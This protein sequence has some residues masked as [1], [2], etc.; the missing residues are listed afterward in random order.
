MFREMVDEFHRTA[1]SPGSDFLS[2]LSELSGRKH[3]FY[4]NRSFPQDSDSLG[5]LNSSLLKNIF[6]MVIEPLPGLRFN[7]A[8]PAVKNIAF[9]AAAH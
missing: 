7:P 1:V 4:S 9:I 6:F 5:V 3:R 8:Y 2:V